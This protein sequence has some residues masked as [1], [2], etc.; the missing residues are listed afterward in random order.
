MAADVGILNRIQKIV[1][2]D[3]LTRE[4]A[5][6]ARDFTADEALQYGRDSVFCHCYSQCVTVL[7]LL[8]FTHFG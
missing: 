8:T 1:G 4:L 6:T 2:N 5:Y 3:S 7:L